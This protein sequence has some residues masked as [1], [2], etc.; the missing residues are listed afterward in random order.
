ML[1][2]RLLI[3]AVIGVILIKDNQCT[4]LDDY[5]KT[6]DPHFNWTVIQTYSEPDYILYIL[7]F[8]SQKWFDGRLFD[9]E[10]IDFSSMFR[11]FL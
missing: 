10:Y 7:N 5:V 2:I 11:L 6:P 8:T 1:C 9:F 3:V 4:P